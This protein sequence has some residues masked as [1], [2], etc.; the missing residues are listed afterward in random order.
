M[1]KAVVVVRPQGRV[2]NIGDYIQ[3]ISVLQ[4]YENTPE[5]IDRE[6]LH[7]Y[8]SKENAKINIVVNGCYVWN[9]EN[10]PPSTDI[11]PLFVSMHIFPMAEHA[12]FS[13][14]NIAYW[15][16][17]EPIG[18]RDISTLKMFQKYDIKAY[19]SSCVTLTL[20]KK[21]K[22]NGIR[23]GS[24]FVDPYIPLPLFRDGS[25]LKKI[26][27]KKLPSYIAFYLKNMKIINKLSTND[28][29]E[30]YGPNW[31]HS[32][33]RS[34]KRTLMR[35]YHTLEFYRI[36]S[37]KF[38]DELLLN[39]E[40][41][42]HM[43]RLSKKY[44]ESDKDLLNVAEALIKK[45]A[46]AKLVVTSRIHSALPCLGLNTPV[47]FCLN[48]EMESKQIQFNTPGRFEGIID[49]FRVLH[50][51]QKGCHTNDE[52]LQTMKKISIHTTFQNKTKYK[53]Y[54]SQLKSNITKFV[55]EGGGMI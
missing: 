54:A 52:I 19:Y 3:S 21:Y 7:T 8:S 12:M 50:I 45:Y 28:F 53:E 35:Y 51:E 30:L 38:S 29:F 1:N 2:K 9:T 15:K 34:F 14:R 47:I 26:N 16:E 25:S 5:L 41:I 18:C 49:L 37:Q 22:Y 6:K 20:D 13:N 4:Y 46:R 27:I 10:W 11:N 43:Y 23:S 42:T 24:F 48:S 33:Y 40:Y 32:H 39:S 17:H 31:G 55:N 36:Y 44:K